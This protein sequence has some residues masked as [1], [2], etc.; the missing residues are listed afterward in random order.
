MCCFDG[1]NFVSGIPHDAKN[2]STYPF[3][4][5]KQTLDTIRP[6]QHLRSR[7]N[8][9]GAIQR[10]RSAITHSTYTYFGDVCDMT[11]VDIPVSRK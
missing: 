8:V 5:A 9:F 6:L 10:I 3:A 11:Y 2:N 1:V 4:K 7:T